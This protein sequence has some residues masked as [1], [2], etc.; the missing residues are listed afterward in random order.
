MSDISIIRW[1]KKTVCLLSSDSC[2][3]LFLSNFDHSSL[4]YNFKMTTFFKKQTT[5]N[6]SKV[7]TSWRLNIFRWFEPSLAEEKITQ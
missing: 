2:Q 4:A 6:T 5:F 7:S 3:Q 1:T